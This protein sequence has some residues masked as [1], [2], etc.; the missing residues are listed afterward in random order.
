MQKRSQAGT[1]VPTE[2][3]FV[4]DVEKAIVQGAELRAARSNDPVVHDALAFAA[5]Q[6]LREVEPAVRNP[7]RDAE[8]RQANE[9][10]VSEAGQVV[11]VVWGEEAFSP[12]QYNTFRVGPFKAS[13]AVRRG[14]T[15][16]QA[17]VRLH[18]ELDEAARKVSIEKGR[19]FLADL[20]ASGELARTR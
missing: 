2:G 1:R 17:C 7:Y 10:E 13:T 19:A 15:I 20:K 5:E 11:E 6:D 14:E 8:Q 3:S 4:R 18:R 9:P 16:G 12:V